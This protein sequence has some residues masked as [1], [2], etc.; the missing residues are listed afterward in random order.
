M[1]GLIDSQHSPDC[2]GGWIYERGER[3]LIVR[4]ILND[5]V[6]AEASV[7]AFRPDLTA[8]NHGNVGFELN[9]STKLDVAALLD[10]RIRVLVFEADSNL[11]IGSPEISSS[12]RERLRH[13]DH[14]KVF[15]SAA[16]CQA[17]LIDNLVSNNT[18]GAEGKKFSPIFVIAFQR[19]GTNLLRHS[20]QATGQVVDCNEVFDPYWYDEDANTWSFWRFKADYIKTHSIIVPTR[21][22]MAN[23]WN[24]YIEHISAQCKSLELRALID[25]KVNSLHLFNVA[26]Q[27]PMEM[28]M[29]LRFL[30]GRRD[31]I[32]HLVRDNF[33]DLYVSHLVAEKSGRFVVPVGE[34]L[35][36]NAIHIETKKMIHFIRNCEAELKL[37]SQWILATEWY[38]ASVL[39]LNY[40]D[41]WSDNGVLNESVTRK[42]E[43]QFG[44]SEHSLK[45]ARIA[46]GKMT[47]PIREIVSNYDSEVIP[48]LNDAGYE[49]FVV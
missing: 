18:G 22:E 47:P 39:R 40:R 35:P 11:L 20:L 10:G 9:F 16:K 29:L 41:L 12:L 33:L 6:L 28:P 13:K 2:L 49:R 8:Q 44:F 14:K 30:G 45:K 17:G 24:K 26:W 27:Q 25:I 5:Q 43:K 48:A 21:R 1:E 4:A 32:I 38:G 36:V 15:Q 19:S 46:T 7:G 34:K 23:L 3:S 37:I 31:Q 42:I